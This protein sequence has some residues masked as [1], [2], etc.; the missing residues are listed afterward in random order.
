MDAF[1]VESHTSF[2][3]RPPNVMS[4]G[5]N[6]VLPDD[7]AKHA[8]QS[9]RHRVGDN[10]VLVD[11]QGAKFRTE[12]LDCW[13]KGSRSAEGRR[14]HKDGVVVRVLSQFEHG[15]GELEKHIVACVPEMKHASR[16]ETM[17]EKLT[18]LGVKEI[19][20]YR[21]TRGVGA[22]VRRQRLLSVIEAAMKQC[23]R[24]VVPTV[25]SGVTLESVVLQHSGGFILHPSR[26]SLGNLLSRSE[27]FH[28]AVMLVGPESGFTPE[29]LEHA[30]MHGWHVAN[31]T[32]TRMRVET[33]AIVACGTI[34]C[35]DD[36]RRCH[37]P[38]ST[39]HMYT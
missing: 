22:P 25:T 37:P 5:N 39:D 23:G 32:N 31:L 3:C 12:I 9:M 27:G 2:L 38:T 36:A 6:V 26:T 24:S 4:I 13:K 18:E 15:H 21:S 33:A 7:E 1:G 30:V 10:L 11:G 14:R 19:I 8:M 35:Y 16:F 28:R 17:V 20:V 34:A 29:E